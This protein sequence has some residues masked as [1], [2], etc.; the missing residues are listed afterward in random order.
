MCNNVRVHGLFFC[1]CK[2]KSGLDGISGSLRA[3]DVKENERHES[4]VDY[5]FYLFV[6]ADVC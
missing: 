5:I 6:V 3:H 4:I 2:I 1:P